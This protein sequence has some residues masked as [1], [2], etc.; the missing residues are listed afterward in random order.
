[1]EIRTF[2]GIPIISIDQ[3]VSRIRIDIYN[4]THIAYHLYK[5]FESV[6]IDNNHLPTI[7]QSETKMIYLNNIINQNDKH[8]YYKTFILK[9][10]LSQKPTQF[11]K[12]INTNHLLAAIDFY[13]TNGITDF[14]IVNIS[15]NPY[16]RFFIITDPTNFVIAINNMEH[17]I[18][19]NVAS[20]YPETNYI[21]RYIDSSLELTP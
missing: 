9:E 19:F 4:T 21:I 6:F 17:K 2:R 5:R 14:V 12:T 16:Q 8:Y 13:E 3:F 1:M 10:F 15:L 7:E 18:R 11:I 20:L